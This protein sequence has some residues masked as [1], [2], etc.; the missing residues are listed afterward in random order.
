M[1]EG[2]IMKQQIVR[3]LVIVSFIAMVVVNALANLLPINGVTSAAVSDSYSNLFAPAGITFAIWSIIYLLLGIYSI[4][5]LGV[6]QKNPE[7]LPNEALDTMAVPFTISSVANLMWIFAWHFNIIW[8]SLILMIVIFS[9]LAWI[10][11]IIQRSLQQQQWT[12]IQR[13]AI[14]TPISVYF[15]WISIATIANMTTFLVS[16]D[17]SGFG[18]SDDIWMIAVVIIGLFVGVITTMKNH[19]IAYGIVFI[20]AYFGIYLKHTSPSG[21][22]W[23][24]PIIIWTVVGS[25]AILTITLLYVLYRHFS[26]LAKHKS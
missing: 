19:D 16:I 20:W 21:F 5:Q 4:Y 24:Y 14:Q 25:I 6:F 15:G 1:K 17:F 11:L 8:L 26:I 2:P 3:I 13:F 18:I 22:D 23:Q 7:T 9:M 12:S 10:T